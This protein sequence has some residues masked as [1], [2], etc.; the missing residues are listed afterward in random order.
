MSASLTF[1]GVFFVYWLE[2]ITWNNCHVLG[3]WIFP[4]QPL[5]LTMFDVCYEARLVNSAKQKIKTKVSN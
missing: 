2:I 5:L 4:E 3:F 1:V